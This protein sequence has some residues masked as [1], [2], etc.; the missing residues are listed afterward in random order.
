MVLGNLVCNFIDKVGIF[1]IVCIDKKVKERC[2]FIMYINF[3]LM[4]V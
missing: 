2:V 3:F 4:I 1:V